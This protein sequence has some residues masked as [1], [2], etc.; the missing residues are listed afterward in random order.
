MKNIQNII[1]D[2]GGVILNLDNQKTEDAFV[3]MGAKNFHEYFRTGF[4]AS[5][6]KDYE[7]GKITDRQFIGGLRKL[8]TTEVSDQAIVQA[9]NAMLG[10]FPAER[11]RLLDQ[12]KAKYRLFLLSNTN[13]L[14]LEALNQ[15]YRSSFGPGQLTDH[16][17]QAYY[18][19]L[20]GMR[21]PERKSY[22]WIISKHGLDKGQTLF[23][24]DAVVNVEGAN[25]AGLRGLHLK[26]GMDILDLDW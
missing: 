1:F 5:F 21:K 13:G 10:D 17:E 11:I 23:V 2:L 8:I 26:E 25:A 20:L 12:L 19:H 9:W 4:A 22:E 15:I 24:D 7:L 3:A 18:S 6:F 16:F 14:H